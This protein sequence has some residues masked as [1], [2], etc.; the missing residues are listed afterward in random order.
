[1]G[2]SEEPSE[3]DCEAVGV[4]SCVAR[5]GAARPPRPRPLPRPD[6]EVEGEKL[7]GWARVVRTRRGARG[8]L[9][10]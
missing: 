1:M 8:L 3:S 4:S 9:R 5:E 10:R 6:M 7:E 2:S